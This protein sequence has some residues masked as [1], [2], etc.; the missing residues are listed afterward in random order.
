MTSR[1]TEPR[2]S[3]ATDECRDTVW[4]TLRRAW[5]IEAV[6]VLAEGPLHF[7]EIKRR[8]DG[9]PASTLSTRLDDL[10]RAGLLHRSASDGRPGLVHYEPMER[11]DE[12]AGPLR[13]T[14]AMGDGE[15]PTPP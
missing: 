2:G 15:R 12:L 8:L 9:V 6:V 7:N 13:T 14:E 11:G 5:A 3:P 10:I 1:S 4:P